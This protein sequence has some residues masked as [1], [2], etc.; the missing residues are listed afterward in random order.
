MPS[1]FNAA[2]HFRISIFSAALDTQYAS[3]NVGIE[4]ASSI[5]P[6]TEDMKMNFLAFPRRINGRKARMRIVLLIIS[7][8]S[9]SENSFRSL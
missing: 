5:E 3:F 7:K 9:S 8:F 4:A 1:N 6:S 2:P